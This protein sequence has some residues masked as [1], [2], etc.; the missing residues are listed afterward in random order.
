MKVAKRRWTTRYG[1]A[2]YGTVWHDEGFERSISTYINKIVKLAAKKR[3]KTKN[4]KASKKRSEERGL[5]IPFKGNYE[6]CKS[7][8]VSEDQSRQGQ[9]PL[10]FPQRAKRYHLFRPVKNH[11]ILA[12]TLH[13][14]R[15]QKG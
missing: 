2:R 14:R 15:Q 5:Q 3:V 10:S 1:T 9:V 11:I 8:K 7:L 6:S 13:I 12:Y 4:K